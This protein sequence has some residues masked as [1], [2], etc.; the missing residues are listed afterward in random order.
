MPTTCL[1]PWRS[2]SA[3]AWIWGLPRSCLLPTLGPGTPQSL[4]E[5]P[6]GVCRP[7]HTHWNAEGRSLEKLPPESSFFVRYICI[8]LES[9]PPTHTQ[10]THLSNLLS[11]RPFPKVWPVLREGEIWGGKTLQSRDIK[12]DYSHVKK[13][14]LLYGR[15]IAVFFFLSSIQIQCVLNA[16]QLEELIHTHLSFNFVSPKA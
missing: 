14:A 15:F 10:E 8:Y 5:G 16:F 4:A 9:H 1:G 13:N 11:S 2:G 12:D 7:S 6:L 3:M